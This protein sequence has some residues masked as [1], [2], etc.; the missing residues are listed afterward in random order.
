MKLSKKAFLQSGKEFL[1]AKS[2]LSDGT[3]SVAFD[4]KE[5][6]TEARSRGKRHMQI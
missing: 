1:E 6:E 4:G 5:L 2:S 3:V